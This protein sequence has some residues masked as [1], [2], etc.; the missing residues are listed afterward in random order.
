MDKKVL[1]IVASLFLTLL[2]TLGCEQTDYTQDTTKGPKPVPATITPTKIPMKDST[3]SYHFPTWMDKHGILYG[4]KPG[5]QATIVKST[6]YWKSWKTLGSIDTEKYGEVENVMVSNSGRV[7][8][9]TFK[10]QV[11]VSDPS[12]TSF[13]TGFTF[14]GGYMSKLF[15]HTVYENIILIGSYAFSSDASYGNIPR[16]VYLSTDDGTTWK[17]ILT[18]SIVDSTQQHH[19]HDVEYDPYSKR[20]WVALGDNPN[21]QLMYSDD[22]GST[23]K[24]VYSTPINE[25]K[26]PQFSQIIAFPEGVMFGTDFKN[27]GFYYWKRP[28]NEEH[29][30][31]NSKDIVSTF[32]ISTTKCD[33]V[34]EFATRK[35]HIKQNNQDLCLVPF[36]RNPSPKSADGVPKLYATVNGLTWYEIYSDKKKEGSKDYYGFFNIIGPNPKDAERRILGI[37]KEDGEYFL[38]KGNVPEFK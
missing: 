21:R 23:W 35:W 15:G 33:M 24:K 26:V 32:K 10:G 8:V 9:G 12:Q 30:K 38:F 18:D 2:T 31:V 37:Y 3:V 20:I 29:P 27:D 22:L 6:D 7:I 4:Y 17:K 13:T 1:M 5:K 25:K 11:L 28:I 14:D 36:V 34:Q 19:I 16:E